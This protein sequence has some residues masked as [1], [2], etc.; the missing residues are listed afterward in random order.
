M[1]SGPAKADSCSI[2][3]TAQRT[4]SRQDSRYKS[5]IWIFP[6]PSQ[7]LHFLS[8]K[9]VVPRIIFFPCPPQARH[10]GLLNQARITLAMSLVSASDSPIFI[11]SDLSN[12]NPVNILMTSLVFLLPLKSLV[13][14][15]ASG[16]S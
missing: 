15:A 11:R 5:S 10:L 14:G 16:C 2:L 13:N 12:I 8:P 9:T 7:W 6:L 1:A 4:S 3:A